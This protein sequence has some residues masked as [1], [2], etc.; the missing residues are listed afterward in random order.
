MVETNARETLRESQ[1]K[2][3]K[4]S[5]KALVVPAAMLSVAELAVQSKLLVPPVGLTTGV[6]AT[7][8]G[9]ASSRR[10]F[11]ATAVT[12]G[13]AL[14]SELGRIRDL[15]PVCTL[16][17]ASLYEPS[18]P[19]GVYGCD[20][21]TG[22]HRFLWPRSVRGMYLDATGLLLCEVVDARTHFFPVLHDINWA[23][24]YRRFAVPQAHG[25]HDVRRWETEL[26][27]VATRRNSIFAVDSVG[28]VR[29]FWRAPGEE[30]S[31]HLNCLLALNSTQL[32][33]TAFCR[34]GTA[35]GWET[36][37]EYR[38]VLCSVPDGHD[39]VTGLHCPH[40]PRFSSERRLLVCNSGN[41]ELLEHDH[42]D[43]LTRRLELG[44]WT[45]G[46]CVL[47]DRAYIGVTPVRELSTRATCHIAEVSLSRWTVLR[48]FGLP[49]THLYDVVAVSHEQFAIVRE[50][51]SRLP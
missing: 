6:C 5:Q 41:G 46:C 32:G 44:G 21:D 16:L 4:I 25:P 26:L 43:D 24:E 2:F 37:R 1:L 19:C 22:E 38:G 45:R 50:V 17:L 27:V 48:T 3:S 14:R 10:R 13:P 29:E 49:G 33:I 42:S 8:F 51:L 31:W 20:L 47:G 28:G 35:R 18:S 7:H 30:D 11:Q 15:M 36:H 39:V 9:G 34:G 12:L 23:G 40:S